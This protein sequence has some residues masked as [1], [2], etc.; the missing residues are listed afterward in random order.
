MVT[1][2]G[3]YFVRI[4]EKGIKYLSAAQ[5]ISSSRCGDLSPSEVAASPIISSLNAFILGSYSEVAGH[6]LELVQ[7]YLSSSG[8]KSFRMLYGKQ[9]GRY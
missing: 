3:M 4:S 5:Q 6:T 8:V 9:Q 1:Q 2:H 7:G